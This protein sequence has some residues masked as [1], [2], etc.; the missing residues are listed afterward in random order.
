MGITTTNNILDLGFPSKFRDWIT[1]LISNFTSGV[2]LKG[3]VGHP[4]VHELA[5]FNATHYP[6]YYSSL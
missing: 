4:I 2:L 6:D 3:L 1:V 5:F